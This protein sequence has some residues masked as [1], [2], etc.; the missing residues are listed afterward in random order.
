MNLIEF[1][2]NYTYDEIINTCI[3]LKNTYEPL[4]SLK[5]IGISHDNR[6]LFMIKIGYGNKTIICSAGVH[7]RETINPIVLLRI[8]EEYANSYYWYK[9]INGI[10]LRSLFEEYSLIFVPLLNPDGY[11]I[12]MYGYDA[13]RNNI[14]KQKCI[15][16]QVE[17]QE[18]KY[19]AR[20]IDLN[21]NFP[22]VN[23]KPTKEMRSSLSENETKALVY[24]FNQ[25]KSLSYIDFHSRGESIFYFR[26]EL[27]HEYN[28][29]QREI[30]LAIKAVTGYELENP[31]DEIPINDSGGN[32]VHYYCEMFKM[33]SITVETVKEDEVF[34]LDIKLRD[35]V[36]EQ[37]LPV[38]ITLLKLNF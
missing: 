29:R 28:K 12:A 25:Y 22:S 20:A 34:P 18:W 38:P 16:K 10:N 32:T 33:P 9:S 1:E 14:L 27:N 13:I 26:Q 3:A 37:I 7:A 11:M 24:V 15:S 19:N 31:S 17:H 36:F 30:A 4:I 35:A 8:I 6:E 5:S 2:K 21:R 23:F